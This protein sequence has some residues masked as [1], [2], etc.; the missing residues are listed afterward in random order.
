MAL[1]AAP[2]RLRSISI[3]AGDFFIVWFVGSQQSG[4]SVDY[5]TFLYL[6][7]YMLEP[8]CYLVENV[9]KYFKA[10]KLRSIP[11]HVH[12]TLRLNAHPSYPLQLRLRI[13][14]DS[15]Q[16]ILETELE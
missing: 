9:D 8:H 12:G 13:T 3:H 11:W 1:A 2:G 6:A 14:T 7:T 16:F 4:L 5:P 15:N 10:D